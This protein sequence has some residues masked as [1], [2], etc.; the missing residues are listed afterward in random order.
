MKLKKYTGKFILT[1]IAALALAGCTSLDEVLLDEK[2][3]S[4]T[5]DP[6]GALAAAYDRLGDGTF[7]DN[8]GMI[9]MQDYASD[10]SL[11][12]TRGSDWGDGG[13]WRAMHE[14]TWG[15]DNAVVT[16]NWNRLSNGITRSLTAINMITNSDFDQKTLFLAEAKGLS[17]IH[18]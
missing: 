16:D 18:I 2:L 14:F 10:M 1:A 5:A 4:E 13:K 17:L 3:G 9:A 8:G 6:A 15:P 7:V 12:P 11:L